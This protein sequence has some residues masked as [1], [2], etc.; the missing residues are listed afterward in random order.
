MGSGVIQDSLSVA[1]NT[2][3]DDVLQ[4]NILAFNRSGLSVVD[5][6][7]TASATGLKV[8]VK[9]GVVDVAPEFAPSLAN[10]FPIFPDDFIGRFGVLPADRILMRVRNTTAGALTIF[11]QFKLTNVNG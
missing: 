11:W 1:A 4:N 8:T 10:H 2:Q 5:Y 6:G 9:N 3:V 7:V